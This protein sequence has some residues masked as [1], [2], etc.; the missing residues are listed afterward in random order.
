MEQKKIKLSD[1]AREVL[2][3][4]YLVKDDEGNV[5]ESPEQ[6]FRRVADTVAAAENS[7]KSGPGAQKAAKQFYEIMANMDFLPNSPTLMNAGRPL[8]QLS[9]CFVLPV[10]DSMEEIFEAIKNTALIH[11][12]GGGTGF[13]FS[14]L[15]PSGD[16]VRKT[17]GVSSGPISFMTAFDAATETVKQGGKRRGANMGILRVDHPDIFHFIVAKEDNDKLN[18]FNI[19]VAVTEDFMNALAEDRNYNLLNPRTKEIAG[20][21]NAREVFS[22]IVHQAWKNGE[23]GI[24]FIDRMNEGNPTP[25]IG[26]IESTNPCGE[27]PLLPFE[28]CNLG[29]IN[30]ANF[31][32][33]GEIDYDRLEKVTRTAV[34]FLD[35]VIEVNKYP[36]PEID[37]MTR[38]NRKIGLG[39]M[40]FA[41]LLALLGVRYDSQEGVNKAEEIMKFIQET[42]HQ[43]SRELADERG[44]F[45]NWE[46][47]IFAERGEKI[48]NATITTIAPTGTIS[49]IADA[50]SGVEP[51]FAISFIKNVMDKDEL[52]MIN[53]VFLRI[54]K[55]QG[56]YSE[57]LMKRIAETGDLEGQAEVPEEI[58]DAFVVAHQVSPEWHIRIQAA[59]QKYTDNAV[60]KTVNFPNSATEEDVRKV[61][62]LAYKL[63]CKGVTIYRDGSR[64]EQVLNIGKVNKKGEG[65]SEVECK[66]TMKKRPNMMVGRT[67]QMMTGC[68]KLY[69]TINEDENGHPFELFSTMGKAGG[70]AASQAEAISRMVS[71]QLRSGVDPK[72]IV[73]HLRNI[74]CH[75]PS[76]FG[77][78]RVTSCADAIGK[79]LGQYVDLTLGIELSKNP[80]TDVVT[81]PF[82]TG[83]TTEEE[84]NNLHGNRE[85][86]VGGV[87]PECGGPI[88]YEGGCLVCRGCAYSECA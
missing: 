11:K 28:S 13:S 76:G 52:V 4:R 70:C 44:T 77:D 38:S 25:K 71:V 31:V 9:A 55:E 65:Q 15:R 57:D 42:G 36:I 20:E 2:E 34:R 22:S 19:S 23:P 21:L 81:L 27:Q 79:A 85:G 37:E 62:E 14:R 18:N 43:M 47:S 60:S 58:R 56:F 74:T 63:N 80:V 17:Q 69:V 59:F 12:S 53:P 33:E 48:R 29:S 41:D 30:L 32:R 67:L 84:Q 88:E 51:L 64:D 10:G 50:S 8:G 75:R 1:A 73:K 26:E 39:V 45:P 49:M 61:Y 87:C 40:G 82:E 16:V 66:P 72:L 3:R 68:G 6:L 54:A 35:D 86:H 46:K 5:K 24:V 7:Y 83:P 78:D